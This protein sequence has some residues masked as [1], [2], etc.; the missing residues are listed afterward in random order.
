MRAAVG[1]WGPAYHIVL[2]MTGAMVRVW[3]LHPCLSPM[4][5]C[6]HRWCT[7]LLN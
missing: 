3:I 7:L 1:N 5:A 6:S 2:I 4:A